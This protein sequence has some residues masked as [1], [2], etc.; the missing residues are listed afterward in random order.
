MKETIAVE[1]RILDL[2]KENTLEERKSINV[3]FKDGPKK[4]TLKDPF[5]LEGLEKVL[6]TLSNEMVD[7]EKKVA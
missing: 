5:D 6:K 1:K 4:K 2:Q 3:T 7:I